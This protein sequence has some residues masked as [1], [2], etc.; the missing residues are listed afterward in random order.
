M[1][2]WPSLSQFG[3]KKQ[4]STISILP[5]TSYFLK[6]IP[7]TDFDIRQLSQRSLLSLCDSRCLRQFAPSLIRAH[8]PGA[9]FPLASTHQHLF[10]FDYHHGGGLRYWYIIPA[11]ERDSL[12]Q[13]FQ[14]ET[15]SICLEH[16][17]ILIDP[18]MFDKYGIRYHRIVQYP[19]EIIILAAGALCQ[20]FTE[21]AAWNET[22]EFALPSWIYDG[23][24]NVQI[25]CQCKL[26][27]SSLSKTIAEDPFH[28]DK[29]QKYIDI[30]LN[31]DTDNKYV[32]DTTKEYLATNVTS[33][34]FDASLT[35][36]N[37]SADQLSIPFI[38]TSLFE[39]STQ[40]AGDYLN[41]TISGDNTV[42]NTSNELPDFTTLYQ[43]ETMMN[44]TD[45]LQLSLLEG[46]N[47]RTIRETVESPYMLSLEDIADLL[48]TPPATTLASTSHSNMQIDEYDNNQETSLDSSSVMNINEP[49]ADTHGQNEVIQN[50]IRRHFAGCRKI[51]LKQSQIPP[52][53]KY[54][55]VYHRTNRQAE[56]NRKRRINRLLFGHNCHVEYATGRSQ[57]SNRNQI[58][59]TWNIA[60]RQVPEN[61]TEDLLHNLFIGCQSMKYVPARTV[62]NTKTSVTSATKTK[63]LWG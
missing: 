7:R 63:L 19:N 31:I 42:L 52:Y 1:D 29:I 38:E 51:I 15:D 22:I 3:T 47:E 39:N 32:T 8:G 30:Y 21:N 37:E 46:F 36:W 13:I 41:Q 54:A 16:G 62:H 55:F 40:E 23:H 5:K 11:S 28:H 20:S 17:N 9:I 35:P 56:Y 6:R 25:S 57:T 53:H 61:I 58:S 27:I 49:T 50:D 10:S 60:V 4:I 2:F 34:L 44:S 43:F 12:G 45:E 33:T 59:E 18:L 24:A 48:S 26:P 14:R